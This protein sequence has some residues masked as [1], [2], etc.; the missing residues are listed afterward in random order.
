MKRLLSFALT[1]VL[2]LG[3]AT[4]QKPRYIFYFIGDGMGFQSLG[5]TEA[6]L[7]SAGTD[8]LAAQA[9]SAQAEPAAQSVCYPP[10][11]LAAAR[12]A[13]EASQRREMQRDSVGFTPLNF[14][15]FPVV[16][17][18]TTYCANSRIT[19]S[20][21][22]GTALATGTKTTFSTM[23]MD[24]SRTVALTSIA[25]DAKN[26]GLRVGIITSV[27]IDHATPAAFYAHQPTR[28]MYYPIAVDAVTAGFDLYG[29]AGLLDPDPDYVPAPV[30]T[31]PSKALT[32]PRNIYDRFDAAGYTLVR[33]NDPIPATAKR[34]VLTQTDNYPAD[35]LPLAIDARHDP[36]ALT[37]PALTRKAVEFLMREPD[38]GFFL[39]AEGGQIDWC[40]HANDGAAMVHE[41]MD[42]SRAIAVALEFYTKYPDQTLIVITADHETGGLGLGNAS[43]GY[44][45]DFG[46]LATQR[47]SKNALTRLVEQQANT[48]ERA[49]KLIGANIA[50]GFSDDEW[51]RIEEDYAKSVGK[52]VATAVALLA[53]KAGIGWTTGAHT[54]AYVPVFAIGAGAELFGGRTDNA[55]IARTLRGLIVQ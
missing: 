50:C 54:A 33:G 41:V 32:A 21:A 48:W 13:R 38:K 44:D 52:G 14:T 49:R 29:G 36:E 37:L 47:I 5:L 15:L 43:R 24:T 34:A 3:T 12:Q 55:A 30:K 27:S 51:A 18:A 25:A 26:A 42:F 40:G 11:V 7:V 46:L 17:F 16:G 23:G 9:S 19:D 10:E 28:S 35:A 2:I 45:S 39:M 31:K 53:R 8:P 4:A 20:A 22:S 1:V 6:Y